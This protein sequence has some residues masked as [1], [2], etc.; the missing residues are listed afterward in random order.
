MGGI[1]C[2]CEGFE[3]CISKRGEEEEKI[4]KKEG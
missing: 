1:F 3:E 2:S 4:L